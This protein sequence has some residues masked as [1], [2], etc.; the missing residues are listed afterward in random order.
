[1]RNILL[2]V[3]LLLGTVNRASAQVDKYLMEK[4]EFN[5]YLHDL[6]RDLARWR[7]LTDRIDVSSLKNLSDK[8]SRLME[9]SKQSCL[10]SFSIVQEDIN[11]LNGSSTLAN[12]I[13]LFSDLKD[14]ASS[15]NDLLGNLGYSSAVDI[16]KYNSWANDTLNEY[17]E[18]GETNLKLFGH[19]IAVSLVIDNRIDVAK[20][21]R[22]DLTGLKK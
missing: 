20:I 11:R 7:N 4:S 18:M 3:M 10:Q 17:R 15:T 22:A 5:L 21:T 6:G 16:D 2:L 1:M 9:K 8:N 19:L 13:A 12:Q 14:L